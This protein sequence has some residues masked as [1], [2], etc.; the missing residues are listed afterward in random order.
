MVR[1]LVLMRKFVRNAVILQFSLAPSAGR[2]VPV[3]LVSFKVPVI[4]RV[5]DFPFKC[6]FRPHPGAFAGLGVYK[7][8]GSI[9]APSSED[10]KEI[11]L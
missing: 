3:N 11:V 6:F 7:K 2:S 4:A 5:M 1:V 9:P 10:R 8:V